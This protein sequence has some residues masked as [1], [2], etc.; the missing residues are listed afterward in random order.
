MGNSRF[1][2]ESGT[3][4]RLKKTKKI[5]YSK[6]VFLW[7]TKKY[8]SD[9]LDSRG[10]GHGLLVES[11]TY[12]VHDKWFRTNCSFCLPSV[13]KYPYSCSIWDSKFVKDTEI[14][15]WGHKMS[16]SHLLGS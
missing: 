4:L 3:V 12:P 7:L 5:F 1:E 16:V 13:K 2:K 6:C 9:V 14:Y 10:L 11:V 8:F 15:M